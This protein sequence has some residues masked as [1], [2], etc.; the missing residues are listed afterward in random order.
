M[1]P[2]SFR[3]PGRGLTEVMEKLHEMVE[4]IRAEKKPAPTAPAKPAQP[5]TAAPPTPPPGLPDMV[6]VKGGTFTMGSPKN[7]EGRYDAE[8]Q[9]PVTLSDFLIGKYP[10]TQQLWKEIM[11]N[12]PPHFK[13]DDLPVE[14]VSWDDVQEFL[15]KLNARYPGHHFRLPTEA[16]WEY[17]ARGGNLSK[18]FIYAGSNKLDEVAWY[19]G[20][21][22]SKT[23]PVGQKK[24]NELGLFDMSGNVWEWC[25]DWYGD[26]PSQPQADPTGPES[27][28]HRVSRGGSW[29]DVPLHC[30]VACRLYW[31][32]GA[33]YGH[34]GFR[35]AASPA[36]RWFAHS[37][38]SIEQT[39]A[40]QG[41]ETEQASEG[42]AQRRR[43]GALRS[44]TL[45]SE[46][47]K[48]LADF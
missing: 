20:N 43:G 27:G 9:H 8:T 3:R 4:A 29:S 31:L 16:E 10:V 12:N 47:L 46:T 32:P 44:E 34:L 2:A 14:Q 30:R 11:G 48:G 15:K 25:A 36:V 38:P 33:R 6:P 40:T 42:R 26:Y 19:S 5:K 35:L 18:G 17:A 41:G 24:A 13:G 1:K 39:G 28:A 21:S 45:R 37:G 7:E 22:G 23:H